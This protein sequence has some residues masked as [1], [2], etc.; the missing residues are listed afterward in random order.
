MPPGAGWNEEGQRGPK[1]DQR[2]GVVDVPDSAKTNSRTPDENQKLGGRLLLYR[3]GF[4][5]R[6]A[7]D[8]RGHTGFA[9]AHTALA[10]P[11]TVP[12]P[13]SSRLGIG[14]LHQVLLQAASLTCP[15]GPVDGWRAKVGSSMTHFYRLAGQ[16]YSAFNVAIPRSGLVRMVSAG[17]PPLESREYPEAAR[18]P[19]KGGICSALHNYGGVGPN[20]ESRLGAALLQQTGTQSA[21]LVWV[22]T[23]RSS[24][25][26]WS[27]FLGSTPWSCQAGT[28]DALTVIHSPLSPPFIQL[29]LFEHSGM[30]DG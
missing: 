18:M 30:F 27:L 17:S 9:V 1:D 5:V 15:I 21:A 19:R 28:G 26:L 4:P 11:F 20:R 13:S 14:P 12:A 6:V 16:G 2:V 10:T 7:K 25:T 23:D 8:Q 22:L 29:G 24:L 3:A